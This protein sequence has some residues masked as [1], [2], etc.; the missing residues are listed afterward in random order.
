MI[1]DKKG[2][3]VDFIPLES[4]KAYDH[5]HFFKRER[6]GK[7]ATE[8]NPK[9]KDDTI[10]WIGIYGKVATTGIPEHFETYCKPDDKWYQIYIYSPKKT[11]F[12]SVFMDITEQK[13]KA[14]RELEEQKESSSNFCFQKKNT[15]DS[16]KQPKTESWRVICKEK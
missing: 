9:I 11:F 1:Y 4:N 3:P 10:D 5:I 16:T 14:E 15:A 2:K 13:K 12:V 8:F 6:I 7:K